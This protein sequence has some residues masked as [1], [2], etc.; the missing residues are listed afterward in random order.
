MQYWSI[1]NSFGN[2]LL[3]M[4]IYNRRVVNISENIAFLLFKE[5]YTKYLIFD[6]IYDYAFWKFLL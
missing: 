4:H 1:F 5:M 3:C 2:T 6:T